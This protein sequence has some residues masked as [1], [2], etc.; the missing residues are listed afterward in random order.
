LA[1]SLGFESRWKD[2]LFIE[3]RRGSGS[4]AVAEVL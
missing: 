2:A 3:V 4:T 1:H